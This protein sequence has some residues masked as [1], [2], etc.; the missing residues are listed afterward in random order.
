MLA[1]AQRASWS[2]PK[3]RHTS[4][5]HPRK[6]LPA[7]GDVSRA[8]RIGALAVIVAS[9]AL[10]LLAAAAVVWEVFLVVRWSH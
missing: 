9:V 6:F 3:Q 10:A 5:M 8:S 2:C 1:L 7:G 4:P